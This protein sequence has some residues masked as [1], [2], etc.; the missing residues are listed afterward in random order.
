MEMYR[1]FCLDF[2]DTRAQRPVNIPRGFELWP[3]PAN[4]PGVYTMADPLG[5]LEKGFGLSPGEVP[6]GEEKFCVLEGSYV[7]LVRWDR[8]QE[9]FTFA[10]P[11]RQREMPGEI[12][13]PQFRIVQ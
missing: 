8:P 1:Q 13:Q 10:V 7:T 11:A 3:S 9:P 4:A 6:Q 2:F 12:A 5:S